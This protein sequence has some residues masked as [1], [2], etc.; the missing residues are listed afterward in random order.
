MACGLPTIGTNWS[1]NTAFMTS[2]NSFL[3]DYRLVPVPQAGWHEIPA[4]R[5]HRWAEPDPE[6]LKALLSQVV[7]RREEARETG[8][9][10]RE[11]V[12]K[13]F[14]LEA[15]GRKMAEALARLEDGRQPGT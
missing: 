6:H 9:W 4:Y 11:E 14:S 8:Q 1:G 12:L 10:A 3:L 13:R 15:V 2:E 7:D 5:G